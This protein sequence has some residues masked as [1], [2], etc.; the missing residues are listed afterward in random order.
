[1]Y[2]LTVLASLKGVL[3]KGLYG[4]NSFFQI[5][6]FPKFLF[7]KM[8]SNRKKNLHTRLLCAAQ[9]SE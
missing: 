2:L 4:L 1:M 3:K 9:N 6:I 7:E 5:E 8:S